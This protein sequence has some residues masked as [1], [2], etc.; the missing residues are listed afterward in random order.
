MKISVAWLNDLLEPG[1]LTAHQ[2]E[3]SLTFAGFP[4]ET[5]E[6]ITSGSAAGD[7]CLDVEVTSNRG[8]VLSHLGVAREICA[9]TK[10]TMKRPSGPR[11]A[12]SDSA[13]RDVERVV[14]IDNRLTEVPGGQHGTFAPCSRFTARVIRGVKVGPSPAWLVK[15]L[16]AVGQRSINNVVDVTNYVSFEMGQPSHVFDLGTLKKDASGRA[17]IVVRTAHKGEKLALLDGKTI[18]LVGDEVVVAD[19]NLAGSGDAKDGAAIS[20]AGVM[21]GATTQVTDSTTD[22]LFEAATWAPVAV[23]RAARRFNIRTDA[24]YRFERI[25]DPRTIDAAAQRA[26]D[27]IL[28][29]AGGKLE[30]GSISAGA[31]A[32]PALSISLRPARCN[33]VLGITVPDD[34]IIRILRALEIGVEQG[35]QNALHCTI[36]AHRPDLEREIDLIEEIARVHGLDKL[37]VHDRIGVRAREPQPSERA[38]RI[39][40]QTLAAHGFYETVTFTFT[41]SKGAKP[42][43]AT[44]LQTMEVCDERRK[45]DPVLR[46]SALPSLLTCRRANQDSGGD[47]EAAESGDAGVRLFE[48]SSVFAQTPPASKGERGKEVE[49]FIVSLVADAAFPAGAKAFEQK[50]TG[51]RFMRAVIESLAQSLGGASAR[52]SFVDPTGGFPVEAYDPAARAGVVVERDGKKTVLGLM[53][54]LAPAQQSQFGLDRPVVMAELGLETL[55][56][57]FPARALV[58]GLPAFPAIERD[59]SLIVREDVTWE[60]ILSMVNGMKAERLEHTA[61]VT[62]YRGAQAGPGRKSVTL[63]MRFRDPARTLRHEEV[64]GPV[65]QIIEK[66][67]AEL[68]A[69]IRV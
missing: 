18:T 29:L 65:N 51:V 49:R 10:R 45:A 17:N 69:E 34:E 13:G 30:S 21:G 20:L 25:V 47:R 62:T 66:A 28:E 1:N 11:T 41:S 50:Q 35:P 39:I 8:D 43:L 24:S 37:P 6:A 31:P 44:G 33:A 4:I 2:A 22:I 36:P 5:A 60:K 42:F 7:T 38:T 64:D 15:K 55:L 19:G 68:G 61:F 48:I 59:L 23:R 26:C 63:R 16:E 52:V 9:S 14:H 27:L 67:K 58:H 32:K 46:P 54:L 12:S 57:L 53:G 56:A 40:A 3:E